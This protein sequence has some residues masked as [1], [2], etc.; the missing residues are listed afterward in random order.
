MQ[1]IPTSNMDF[2]QQVL[3]LRAEYHIARDKHSLHGNGP[4]A[5][6]IEERDEERIDGRH[7]SMLWLSA[8]KYIRLIDVPGSLSG[9]I[10][11]LRKDLPDVDG[12]F[13]IDGDEI[14]QI[15]VV[16]PWPEWYELDDSED[17]SQGLEALPTIE[18]DEDIH[19][20][21]KSIYKSEI[22]TL[23]KCQGGS[24]P[25]PPLSTFVIRLLGK[26]EEGKLVFPA[27]RN[28]F[29]TFNRVAPSIGI[30]KRWSS[31]LV[32]AVRVLHKIDVVHRDLHVE[33]L[34]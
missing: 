19:H 26:T 17:V 23:L 25:G 11:R 32:E 6:T 34:L 22:Q 24:C 30:Y 7:I 28:R 9:D 14:R 33:N 1:P 15:D 13:E 12:N 29:Y 10:L 4:N 21:K 5:Y 16:P 27:L 20:L 2:A 18:F 3:T 31:Q 8:G